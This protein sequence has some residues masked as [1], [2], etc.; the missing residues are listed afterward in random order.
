[1]KYIDSPKISGGGSSG[2][3]TG[4]AELSVGG[5]PEGK[6]FVN[7][8]IQELFDAL[9]KQ[10]KFPTLIPPSHTFVASIVGLREVGEIVNITFT[11]TFNRGQITPQYGAAEP[12]RSGLPNAYN[13]NGT[14]LP[15]IVTKTDLSDVQIIT[16]YTITLGTQSWQCRV[17]YDAGV[18]PKSSYGNDYDHPLPAGATSYITQSINGVYPWFGTSV[19][20]TTLTKQ[21]LALHTATYYQIAM[22]GETDTDKQTVD[23]P[24]AFNAITGVQFYNTI[25]GQWEWLGGSKAASLTYWTITNIQHTIN[26]NII[27]YNRYMHNNIKTGARQLRFYTT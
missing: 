4:T 18:Q 5:I 6:S 26:G 12:Y 19:D 17:S 27:S 20:I 22:V 13:Y 23:F 2:T 11:A 10:E 1:M 15:N 24:V 8:T 14:G 21:P 16:N 7:A 25:S 3:Y 9:L